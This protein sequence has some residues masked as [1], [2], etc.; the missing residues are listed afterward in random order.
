[1]CERETDNFFLT[2]NVKEV[3]LQIE[4]TGIMPPVPAHADKHMPFLFQLNPS[5]LQGGVENA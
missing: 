1:M 3:S 4:T 5:Y 2:E